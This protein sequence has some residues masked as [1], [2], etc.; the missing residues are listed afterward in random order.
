MSTAVLT[1]PRLG[2]NSVA[3]S[4]LKAAGRFWFVVMVVGQLMF[5]FRLLPSM[6]SRL[7]EGIRR[8]RGVDT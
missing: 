1:N 5:A 4:A 8:R 6:A 3:E 2:L 7:C